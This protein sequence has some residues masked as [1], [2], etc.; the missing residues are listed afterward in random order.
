MSAITPAYKVLL[1]GDSGV[2]K[3]SI[4]R[5]FI[6]RQFYQEHLTTIGIDYET[7]VVLIDGNPV[8]LSI[9]D[10]A[11]QERFRS[12]TKSYI[13]GVDCI[14]LV[15]DITNLDSF[16]HISDWIALI[17]QTDVPILITV[18]ANKNDLE[19]QR[20]ISTESGQSL[21]DSQNVPFYELSAKSTET[22]RALFLSIARTLQKQKSRANALTKIGVLGKPAPP[23]NHERCC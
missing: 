22:V 15:Y 20:V 16:K 11:G 17:E 18:V 21:S 1:L 6:N 7:T 13:R 3:T 5:Q 23:G 19:T 12:I 9:W 2:G 14:I 10:T 8:K 4:L